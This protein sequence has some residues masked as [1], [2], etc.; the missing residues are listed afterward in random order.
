MDDF[1][2]SREI[3]AYVANFNG[4]QDIRGH[5]YKNFKFTT[6]KKM[7]AHIYTVQELDQMSQRS[8]ADSHETRSDIQSIHESQLYDQDQ[9]FAAENYT[10]NIVRM[11]VM[12]T[13]AN[14]SGVLL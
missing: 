7:L 1:D 9:A 14:F 12:W 13:A 4:V 5:P 6:E 8:K 2:E 10:G 3:L 11:T